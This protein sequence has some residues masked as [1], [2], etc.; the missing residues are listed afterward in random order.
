MGQSPSC[1]NCSDQEAPFDINRYVDHPLITVEDVYQIKN[2]FDYLGPV[3]GYVCLEEIGGLRK[4]APSYLK[5]LVKTLEEAKQDLDF[6][7]FYKIMKPKVI[8]LK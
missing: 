7:E 4:S 2:C 3:N 6:D 1:S 5:E 8:S